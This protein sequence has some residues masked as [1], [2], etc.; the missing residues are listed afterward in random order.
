M[1]TAGAILMS[2]GTEAFWGT[3]MGEEG[4]TGGN[5]NFGLYNSYPTTT[6]GAGGQNPKIDSGDYLPYSGTSKWYNN[7]G[8]EYNITIGSQFR[9]RS[10]FTHSFLVGGLSLIHI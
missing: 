1:K 8:Q 7:N 6:T 9:Y 4:S 3:A 10:V 2:N 5:N